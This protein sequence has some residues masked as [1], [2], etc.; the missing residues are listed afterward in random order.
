[1]TLGDLYLM[2]TDYDWALVAEIEGTGGVV[3]IL[4]SPQ[5]SI[6]KIVPQKNATAAANPVPATAVKRKMP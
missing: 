3:L 2:N 1:M 5:C 6:K 4:L